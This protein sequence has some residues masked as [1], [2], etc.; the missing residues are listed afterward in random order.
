MPRLLLLNTDLERGGTPTVVRELVRRLPTENLHVEVACLAPRGP[1]ADEIEAFGGRVTCF[2]VTKP[3]HLPAAVRRLRGLVRER[4]IDTALSFLVHANT[5]AALASRR[6]PGVRFFQSIQTVQPKPRWHWWVQRRVWRAAEKVIVPS[7][8]VAA[9]ARERCGVPAGRITVIPNALDPAEFPRIG[10]FENPTVRVGFL[11]RLDP[12]KDVP[13]F[14]RSVAR[15]ASREA[16]VRVEGH[17]YGEGPE[18]KVIENTIFA[19]GFAERFALHGSVA[20]PQAALREIDVLFLPSAGEGFGLVLI[21]AMAS[22]VPV[23]A[24][25]AGGAADVVADR[26]NGLLLPAT[27]GAEE[28][29][30]GLLEELIRRPAFRKGLIANGLETVARRFGWNAVLPQ[31]RRSLDLGLI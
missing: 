4:Q 22:G 27:A 6:L 14:V 29:F 5:V 28:A 3:W 7:E 10:V 20:T 13:L 16:G 17:I 19:C 26:R 1:V 15:A 8:A 21:E 30:A 23:A 2:G 9:V 11:G 31:Y 12:V 25:N 18:R 24:M